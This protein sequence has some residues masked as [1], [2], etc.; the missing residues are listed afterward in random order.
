MQQTIQEA[1]TR[2]QKSIEVLKTDL[3]KIRTGRAN[4]GLLD[5]IKV[6]AYG[7]DSPLSQVASITVEGARS[8]LVTPWDKTLI[9]AIE[10]AIMTSDLGLNPSSAG[11]VIR[12]PMPAL[13]EERRREFVKIVRDEIETARVA[14]RS[15]RRDANQSLKDMLKEKLI[16]EDEGRRS[17][18]EVQKMTDKYIAEIDKLMAAKETELMEI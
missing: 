18:T 14:I 17:E 15:I 12:V 2:M 8:L 5:H 13:T 7:T 6:P 11:Q 16:N 4:P 3:A 10:K 9:S 1:N